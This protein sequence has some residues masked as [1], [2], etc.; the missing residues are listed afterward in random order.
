M[1]FSVCSQCFWYSSRGLIFCQYT[2]GTR[3]ENGLLTQ[4]QDYN[5]DNKDLVNLGIFSE[6]H[7][8]V[9]KW[10]RN[11]FA[12]NLTL[13]V[14]WQLKML[15]QGGFID[16]RKFKLGFDSFHFMIVAWKKEFLKQSLLALKYGILLWFLV[17]F[18]SVFFGIKLRR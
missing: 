13:W 2:K 12:T 4:C 7:V 8:Y 11:V 17:L 9:E 3:T 14:F 5:N 6:I 1:E 15:L 10:I 16:C 18:N